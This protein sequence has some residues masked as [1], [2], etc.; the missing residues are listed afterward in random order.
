MRLVRTGGITIA[1]RERTAPASQIFPSISPS[2]PPA[3]KFHLQ[4]ARCAGLDR[5]SARR[6]WRRTL[7]SSFS[8]P[9]LLPLPRGVLP[10]PLPRG[11]LVLTSYSPDDVLREA[12]EIMGRSGNS[13]SHTTTRRRLSSALQI[14][15]SLPP[16][17]PS[18]RFSH[19]SRSLWLSFQFSVFVALCIPLF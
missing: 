18:S 8:L 10:L 13:T 9:N 16:L 5:Q 19:P 6:R 14:P 1:T 4:D 3:S 11:V 7:V 12:H 15:L 2:P 17:P